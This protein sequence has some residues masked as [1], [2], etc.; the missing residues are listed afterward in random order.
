[1][2]ANFYSFNKIYSNNKISMS[3]ITRFTEEQY[4]YTREHLNIFVKSKKA[5]ARAHARTHAHTREKNS[6]I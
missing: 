3:K 5:R 4:F 6:F 1:M 2:Q